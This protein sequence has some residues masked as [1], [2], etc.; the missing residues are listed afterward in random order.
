M[1]NDILVVI[2]SGMIAGLLG[3][4][5]AYEYG[6][7]LWVA[8]PVA[9]LGGTLAWVFCDLAGCARSVKT[10]W[11]EVAEWQPDKAY[12]KTVALAGWGV[13]SFVFSTFFW[14]FVCLLLLPHK[15]VN[16]GT[17]VVTVFFS[18]MLLGFSAC[19]MAEDFT[20]KESKLCKTL[21]VRWNIVTLP[22]S[23]LWY[24]GK[25]IWRLLSRMA[26]VA[27]VTGKF[28]WR[29][30]ILAHSTRRRI[31]FIGTALGTGSGFVFAYLNGMNT[32]TGALFCG[33]S[34]GLTFCSSPCAFSASRTLKTSYRASGV[35]STLFSLREAI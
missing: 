31:C 20:E 21:L 26:S 27:K 12:L 23:V 1:K 34:S 28:L 30:F 16:Y 18:S 15:P 4:A 5:A 35:S 10:A 19:L 8:V 7:G 33:V 6:L 25:G 24:S 32:F 2:F 22:L 17:L 11:R 13:F 14:V 3:L 9:L 29:A